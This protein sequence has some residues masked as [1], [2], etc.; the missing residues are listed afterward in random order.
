M[1]VQEVQQTGVEATP[2]TAVPPTVIFGGLSVDLNTA[3]AYDEFK[4]AGQLP[5][6]IV[7]E[8]QEWGAGTLSGFPT[9]TE[10]QYPISNVLG[11]ATITTPS[12][13]TLS[14]RWLWQP[15]ESTPWV[16]KTWTILRGVSGDTAE[17]A[18]YALMSGLGFTFSRTAAPTLS[19]DLFSQRLD[20]SAA[21]A[22]TGGTRKPLVPILP[23][24]VCI[25]LDPTAAA[26]GT[27]KLT[28]DFSYAWTLGSLFDMAWALDCQIPSYSAHTVKAPDVSATLQLGNDAA[29]RA[30]VTNM[31][32]GTTVFVR[33]E[34]TGSIIETA[35]A[36]RLRI[37][38]ALK[39]NDAPTRG[40]VNGLST[41][42]WKF[43][44]VYDATWGHWVSIEL[45][46]DQ[47]TL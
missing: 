11:A 1:I 41:L 3:N 17:Q 39:V 45:T 26:L 8:R 22:A 10:L 42:E 15:S 9:Y 43:R 18:A 29:G 14:R 40:D 35:I 20:N 37:D 5:Q 31:R 33:L 2:G 28:R 46:N 36:Y 23:S 13:A 25:Y 38:A 21:L 32:A 24:Q 12:G 16:P 27:T 44:N 19:G 34:A 6:S 47:S 30:L 7:A 4:P